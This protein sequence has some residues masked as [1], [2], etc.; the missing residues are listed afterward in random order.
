LVVEARHRVS[1]IAIVF[2]ETDPKIRQFA[3]NTEVSV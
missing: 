3:R 2:E 1:R